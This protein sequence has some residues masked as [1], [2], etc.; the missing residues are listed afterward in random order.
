MIKTCPTCKNKPIE[1]HYIECGNELCDEFK[2]KYL[3]NE[4]SVLPRLDE[5]FTDDNPG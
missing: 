5:E 1:D 4:W 3:R 2:V